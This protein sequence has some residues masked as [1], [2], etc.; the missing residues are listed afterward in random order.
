[1]ADKNCEVFMQE[2]QVLKLQVSRAA[3]ALPIEALRRLAEFAS[4]LEEKSVSFFQRHHKSS[5]N[6]ENGS[7]KYDVSVADP[8]D[9][10]DVL[11][12]TTTDPDLQAEDR[13]IA[14][15][16]KAYAQ[17]H[18]E[19]LLKYPRQY[20]A[21]H[22]GELVDRD[23]DKIALYRRLAEQYGDTPLLVRQVL[24]EVVPTVRIPSFR[25]E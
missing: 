21:I 1:M 9:A 19:L 8:L 4:F 10:Q 6:A 12:Y 18:P 20:V 3:D 5:E 15:E 2:A 13:I 17:M 14:Q 24:P 25:L 22:Q 23:T 16:A 11:T 7:I